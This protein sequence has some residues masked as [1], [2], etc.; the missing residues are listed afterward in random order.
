VGHMEY[1]E[2]RE[3]YSIT[4]VLRCCMSKRT[5]CDDVAEMEDEGG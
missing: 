2:S 4:E 1:G 3:A 5:F